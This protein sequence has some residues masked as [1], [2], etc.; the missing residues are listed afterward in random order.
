V[1]HAG[2]DGTVAGEAGA[3]RHP[4]VASKLA[5]KNREVHPGVFSLLL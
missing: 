4:Q 5:K 2:Q 3:R 1:D